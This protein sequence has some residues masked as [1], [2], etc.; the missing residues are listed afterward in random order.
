MVRRAEGEAESVKISAEANLI[1][2][3]KE[4]NG[5]QAIM[6]AQAAGVN[7][8]I[9][10]MGGNSENFLNYLMVDRD[11]YT[12][13]ADSRAKALVG[14]NPEIK[15]FNMNGSGGGGSGGS[16]SSVSEIMEMLPPLASVIGDYFKDGTSKGKIAKQFKSLEKSNSSR[17]NVPEE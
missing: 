9:E 10:S 2:K 13:L 12:K 1:S 4:A 15:T 7:Q 5:I 3:Q 8:L 17:K 14:L 11:I 16:F 6:E